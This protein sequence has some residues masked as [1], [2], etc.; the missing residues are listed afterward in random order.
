MDCGKSCTHLD[1]RLR[2]KAE[3]IGKPLR[4][5]ISG[6][7]FSKPTSVNIQNYHVMNEVVVD[8]GPSSYAI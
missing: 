8:R 2:L 6:N 1:N 7:D 3:V 5:I 4:Q